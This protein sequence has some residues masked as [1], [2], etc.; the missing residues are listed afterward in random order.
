MV[1]HRVKRSS[2]PSPV[3][4]L[5]APGPAAL[6]QPVDHHLG[7]AALDLPQQPLPVG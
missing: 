1:R 3:A 2:G 6:D 7:G 5:L 4:H